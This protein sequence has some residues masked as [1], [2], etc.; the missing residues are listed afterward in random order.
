MA[1][2]GVITYLRTGI[3]LLHSGVVEHSVRRAIVGVHS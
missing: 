3:T 2:Y 1:K